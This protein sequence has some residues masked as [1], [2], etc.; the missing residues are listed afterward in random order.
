MKLVVYSNYGSSQ[1]TISDSADEKVVVN[2]MKSLDWKGFHQVVLEQENGDWLEVGGSLDPSDGLSVMF[3]EGGKQH[4]I[5]TA[6]TKVEE[7]TEML[8]GYLSGNE[9]WKYSVRWT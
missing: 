7:M 8:L 1:K 3:E 2:T 6:P 4:V 5:E 9:L